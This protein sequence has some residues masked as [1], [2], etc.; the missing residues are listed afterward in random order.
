MFGNRFGWG[1]SAVIFAGA[2]LVAYAFYTLGQP[3]PPTGELVAAVK[4]FALAE[5]AKS[6]LPPPKPLGDAGDLYR[7]AIADY[8]DHASAY[9]ALT[10]T[11]DYRPA[12]VKQ[13][14]GFDD[15]AAAATCPTM[16]LFRSHPEA[17]INFGAPTPDATPPSGIKELDDLQ[18][19]GNTAAYVA[20][21]AAYD[22]DYAT[23]KRLGTAILAL[24]LNLYRERM[25]YGELEA[26][27]SLMGIGS[28]T[29]RSVAEKSGDTAT[30]AA[31]EAFDKA[32]LDENEAAVV[33]PW[34]ILSVQD[35]ARIGRYAGDFFRLAD[36]GA[37]DE[38]WRVE[39]IR[40]LG[41]LQ[42]NAATHAD[43][44][45]AKVYLRNA[46]A[47]ASLDPALHQAAVSARDITPYQNQS[48]R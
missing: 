26:G 14:K 40:R 44:V 7:E 4:P 18:T 33:A 20:S 19:L 46:A 16:D 1:I 24:G 17:I 3:T 39:A 43:N 22:K 45:A 36:D 48:P 30:A 29:L 47:D 38:M 13:L 42:L 32:R 34:K 6:V 41:R 2:L 35:D 37:A 21:L 11:K 23:A 27:I 8:R 15:L 31:H 5:A 12:A 28:A 9:E 25:T 10:N